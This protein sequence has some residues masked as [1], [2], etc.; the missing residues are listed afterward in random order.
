MLGKRV[1][2]MKI[3]LKRAK[4]IQKMLKT[5]KGT[6]SPFGESVRVFETKPKE[7]NQSAPF[8]FLTLA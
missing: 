5:L 8:Q 4:H 3:V 1:F 6:E 7:T 2:F